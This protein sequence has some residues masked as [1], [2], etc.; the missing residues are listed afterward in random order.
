VM[1][2]AMPLTP[3]GKVDRRALPAPDPS[4]FRAE[5]AYAEPRTLVEERLVEIWEEV[6]GLEPVGIHDNFF[7]L[8]GYSLLATRVV[9]RT[10]GALGVELPL[11]YLFE[12]PSVA[13]LALAVTQMQAEEETDI[14]QML[15]QLE[16]IQDRSVSE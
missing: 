1:L 14:E 16:Q 13:G 10:R 5:N 12:T 2:D 9:S 6:L 11:R 15:A 8:G 3:S 7:E 4:G